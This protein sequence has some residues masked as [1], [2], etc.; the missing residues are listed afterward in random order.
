MTLSS[1]TIRPV[2]NEYDRATSLYGKFNSAHE[3]Y[4]V[5]LE[6]VEELW[7]EIKKS[8]KK[9]DPLKMKEEAVQVAAMALRFLNDCCSVDSLLETQRREQAMVNSKID[10]RVGL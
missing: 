1:E 4:A 5:L 3:G 2:A 7:A 6:E 9:R 8:P 10:G